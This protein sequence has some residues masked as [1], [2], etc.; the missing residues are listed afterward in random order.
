M[1][2][3]LF[4]IESNYDTQILNEG[5][6]SAKNLFIEGIFMQGEVV[7]G[8]KRLYKESVLDPQIGEFIDKFVN[9]SRAVGEFDHPKNRLNVD[10]ERASHL[11]TKIE[12]T[13]GEKGSVD[14]KGKAK[15]L[16]GTPMGALVKGL[17]DGGVKLGVSSRGSGSVATDTKGISVV[18]PDFRLVTIDIVYQPSAP[19]AFVEG[20]LE[21]DQFVW[22]SPHADLEFIQNLKEKF[23]EVKKKNMLEAKIEAF[24]AFVNRF[25]VR[26]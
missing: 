18:Q 26:G 21:N 5:E 9:T 15:V 17:L 11:I 7:N 14:W 10:L 20:L 19:N 16:T 25:S 12:K 3:Q 2:H 4:L 23:R 13:K 8:N 6:G 24:N 1:A 22:G